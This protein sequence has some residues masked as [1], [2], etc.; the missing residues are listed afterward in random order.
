M[1]PDLQKSHDPLLA[2]EC[3]P[4]STCPKFQ[5]CLGKGITFLVSHLVLKNANFRKER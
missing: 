2:Y 3:H 1:L 4:N 5:S